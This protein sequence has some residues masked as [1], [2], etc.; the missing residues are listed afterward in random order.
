MRTHTAAG[1][2][3][4]YALLAF[5]TLIFLMPLYLAIV[6]AL[7]SWYSPPV[8]LPV[9]QEW[10]NFYYATTLIDFWKYTGN[11]VI[12]A[13]ITVGLSAFSSGMAG[14]AFARLKAPGSQGLFMIV[15]ATMMIPGIVTQIPTYILFYQMKL[16]DTFWPWVFWGI[17]GSAFYIFMYRQFFLSIPVELE[18]AA[19]IDGCSFFR[20]YWDI[21]LPISK[22]V[23]A[24]VAILTFQGSWN[25]VTGPFMFLT[26]KKYP[27]ATAMSMIGYLA[28]GSTQV[29][30]Q[31][32]L[33]AGILLA[34]PIIVTFFIGQRNIVEGIVTTGLKA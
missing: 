5:C 7:N 25:D 10:I 29:I 32:S 12:L 31:V 13:A 2:W 18:E 27:L 22:P 26:E 30:T 8:L 24:T 20:I 3:V 17:G 19:R 33:A 4:H 11:S 6:N 28:S 21:I 34:I 9:K 14:Y 23:V 16:I 15:L 1:R